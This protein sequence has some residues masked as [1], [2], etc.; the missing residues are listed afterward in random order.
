MPTKTASAKQQTDA[1][2]TVEEAAEALQEAEAL[3]DTLQ[4]EILAGDG[5]VTAADLANAKQGV[6]FAQLQLDAANGRARQA[7]IDAAA[8]EVAATVEAASNLGQYALTELEQLREA[9]ATALAAYADAAER[10][11]L[12]ASLMKQRIESTDISAATFGV[13][14]TG[15]FGVAGM[16]GRLQVAGADISPGRPSVRALLTPIIEPAGLAFPASNN[17]IY[18]KRPWPPVEA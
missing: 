12:A 4:T 7:Q 8:A 11:G 17:E 10:T 1:L 2:P 5:T 18:S 14:G 16:Y 13:A 3:V 9:A 15:L 6:E